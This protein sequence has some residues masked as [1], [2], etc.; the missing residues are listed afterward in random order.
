MPQ[1]P[2]FKHTLATTTR[3]T[4]TTTTTNYVNALTLFLP[5]L[6]V[7]LRHLRLAHPGAKAGPRVEELHPVRPR[8]LG[9]QKNVVGTNGGGIFRQVSIKAETTIGTYNQK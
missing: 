1:F 6:L 2:Y 3:T 4:T 8:V 7:F 5:T 9:R